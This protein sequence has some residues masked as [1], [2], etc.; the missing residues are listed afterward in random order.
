MSDGRLSGYEVEGLAARVSS[1]IVLCHV[2]YSATRYPV[3]AYASAT[4]C[5]VLHKV[6]CLTH[7]DLS[8]NMI[9]ETRYG[10]TKS[11]AMSGTGTGGDISPMVLCKCYAMSGTDIGD[12]VPRQ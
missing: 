8:S 12:H 9:G 10:P 5:P 7:L 2:R 11:Y 3:L 6:T 4:R 1:P